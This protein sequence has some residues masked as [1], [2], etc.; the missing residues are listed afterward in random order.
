MATNSDNPP[1]N[2]L[3]LHGYRQNSQTFREKTGA[4]RKIIKNKAKLVFI[5]APNIVPPLESEEGAADTPIS[6]DQR[7]WWFSRPDDY[8]RAQDITDCDK[9]FRESVD[10]VCKCFKE[11]GPFDGVLGF[12]QG[13]SFLSL[14]CAIKEQDTDSPIQFDFAI[15]VAGFKSRSSDHQDLYRNKV[16]CPS[17]HVYG[18]TDGVIPKDMSEELANDQFI[19]P[20][21]LQHPG[22]HFI[23]ASSAQKKVYLDFLNKMMQMKNSL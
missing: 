4:F 16:S 10:V 20:T 23:P 8:F 15:V 6:S 7:G 13:A 11:E 12:S 1:L 14:L 2:I 5:T 19:E 17:L 9:G 22:G 21:I 3:C 18:E